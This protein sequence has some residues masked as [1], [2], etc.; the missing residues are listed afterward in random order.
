LKIAKALIVTNHLVTSQNT[1]CKS[2]FTEQTS[3]HGGNLKKLKTATATATATAKI[4]A[5]AKTAA[6]EVAV[7]VAART[8]VTHWPGNLSRVRASSTV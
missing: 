8:N 1:Y 7:A 5:K 3:C 2:Y 4:A 6:A